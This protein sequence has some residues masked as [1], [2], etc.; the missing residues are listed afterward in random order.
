MFSS[1]LKSFTSNITSHY[2]LAA[3]PS[4]TSGPWK[5]FDAKR[6]STGKAASVFVFDKR[7]LEPQSSGGG[8]GGRTSSVSLKRAQEEVLERLKKEASSLARLRHPSI[9]ELAEPVEETRN[10]GLMFATEPVTASL[11]SLLA[12][13]D[14]QGPAGGTGERRSRFVVEEAD[15]SKTSRELEIDE[16]EIQKGLLQIGKGLEFLHEGAGLVHANLTPEAV[17]VNAKGDWKISGL[18]FCGPHETST[19]ATSLAPISLSEVLNHDSRLPR[20]VQM[21]LDYTSPDFILDNSLTPSADMFSLGLLIIALYNSPHTSPLNAGDSLSSYKRLFGSSSSIPTQNN[22]FLVPSSHPL[23]PKLVSDLLPRLITRR[24]AQRLT[25]RE[26]QEA[27][28]FDN[29]LVS[30][31]RF[32][33]ALPAKTANEKA[34]FM[35]GLPRIMPQFPKSVLEKKVL[36]ALLEEMKDKDLLAPIISNI[37]AGV[38]I[39]PNGKKAFTEQVVPRLR[40]VFVTMK[41]GGERDTSKEAGL[42]ILLENME[43]AAESCAGKEF[44][45]DILPII[46]LALESPTHAIVDAALGTLPFVLPVL[47][48]STIKNELFPVIAG[49]FAK[50]SS[51]NI[52]I[53]GL[54]AFYILCGGSEEEGEGEGMI[55]FGTESKKTGPSSSS[56]AILDKFTVQEKIVPLLKGIK[57][58]E[59]GV[60]MAA[61]RVFRQVGDV[62]DSDYLA[63]EVLPVLWSMS[64]GPLLNLQQF[65]GFMEL[66]KRLGERIE[67][68]QTRKL[69]ELRSGD[70]SSLSSGAGLR[71]GGGRKDVGVNG[72]TNGE[73]ADFESLVSGRKAGASA[74]DD[75]DFM[76]DWGVASTSRPGTANARS[77]SSQNVSDNSLTFSWQSPTKAPNFTTPQ[78]QSSMSAAL[79]PQPPSAR[80]ITPDQPLSSFAALQPSNHQYS[81]PL[82]PSQFSSSSIPLRPSSQHQQ[83]GSASSTSGGTSIDWSAATK[84]VSANP[85]SSSG[86]FQQQQ[87]QAQPANGLG[88]GATKQSQ[89]GFNSFSLSPPP[90]SPQAIGQWNSPPLQP[91]Q[92]SGGRPG[93]TQQSS[94]TGTQ[95]SG[96]DRYESLL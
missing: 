80:A 56:S 64:L 63:M 2:T 24:P 85:W 36:P 91:L 4:S 13:K 53:K 34:Q 23:P 51:L 44:R 55:G 72:A 33:D 68:E 27:S 73:E 58:K 61:L 20:S 38:K 62:A 18:S 75:N 86:N 26:F 46:L 57:T 1:A 16:L 14:E 67:K 22:N 42:M 54:E 15:G 82:Q 21:N 92:P 29:I 48:F 49:V 96:L 39:M 60:M 31:I 74:G 81:Q 28:Y 65:K 50:T 6:K 95:R 43:T 52:K 69:Q 10:G 94:G 89:G 17:L 90:T 7:S 30:T 3:Q 93:G 40:E 83:Q 66:I 84:N 11:A 9:L 35:R 76:N 37:F 70:S 8:L 78:P 47:D 59:P 19:A 5:I 41:G 87:Q 25:A 32:L 71:Q 45:E 77:Q 88:F 12:E 79:R